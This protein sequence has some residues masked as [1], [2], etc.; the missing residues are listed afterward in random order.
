M[1]CSL[2]RR[3]RSKRFSFSVTC[4]AGGAASGYIHSVDVHPSRK[5]VC[6]VRGFVSSF[7]E[8]LCLGL[9]GSQFLFI[10]P[11]NQQND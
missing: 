10:Y 8:L 5:H 2:V 9:T 1:W 11:W 4:R 7:L 6:V 3:S